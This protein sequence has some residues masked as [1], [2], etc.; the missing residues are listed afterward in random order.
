MGFFFPV[1]TPDVTVTRSQTS[2]TLLAGSKLT[3][4]CDIRIDPKVD[5]LFSVDTLW[6]S[7]DND[8]MI[9]AINST[10][11][12]VTVYD[13]WPIGFNQYRSRVEFSTLSSIEDSGLYRCEV[14]IDSNST[15]TYVFDSGENNSATTFNV[16]GK[17]LETC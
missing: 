12:R 1:P 10:L 2:N 8:E 16:T 6:T 17:C 9:D 4:Y 11:D 14:V 15:Y 7:A 5:T 13:P 3:V